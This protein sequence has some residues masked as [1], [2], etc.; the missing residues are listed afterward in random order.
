MKKKKRGIDLARVCA[1]I[2]PLCSMQLSEHI[3][4]IHGAAVLL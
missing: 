4:G 1:G 2:L 3:H